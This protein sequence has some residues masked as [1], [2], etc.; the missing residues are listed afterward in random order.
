MRCFVLDWRQ[1]WQRKPRPGTG[2]WRRLSPRL[3]EA[4]NFALSSYC[5]R[6]SVMNRRLNALQNRPTPCQH[7]DLRMSFALNLFKVRSVPYRCKYD[8][9]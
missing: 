9:R 4:E 1:H 3:E 7:G 5:K 2:P 8:Q 6:R